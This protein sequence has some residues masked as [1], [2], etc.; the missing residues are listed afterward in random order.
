VGSA[1][2]VSTE[3]TEEL[4]ALVREI[5]D[6]VR[7]RYPSADAA[8]ASFP[9]ADLTALV[10][11]RDVAESKVASIGT[12]NPRPPGLLNNLIQSAKRLVTRALDWHVR[13]QVEF[14]RAAV[15]GLNSA[16]EALN[17]TNRAL[18]HLAR[19]ESDIREVQQIRTDWDLWRQAWER[20]LTESEIRLLRDVT[21][22]QGAFQQRVH[23]IENNFREL[24]R[25]QHGEFR[26]ALDASALEIQQRLWDSLAQLRA[27]QEQLIHSELRL[28]RQRAATLPATPPAVTSAPIPVAVPSQGAFD[29]L[30][31]A[32]RFRGTE[33]RVRGC[34]QTFAER[35]Q[36][37]RNVIDLGCGRGEFLGLMK[38]AGI[39]CRG[40]DSSG[41][42][43]AICR[44][45]Q[46]AA[47]RADIFEY[48]AAEPDASLD[49]IFCAQVIEHLPPNRLP[50]LVR[51]AAAKL[52][53]GG[54]LVVETP[55]PE[56]L[57]IFCTYFYV[58]P[59]HTRPVPAQLLAFYLEEAGFGGIEIERLSPAEE[60]LPALAELPASVREALFGG[61]DYAAIARR[62]P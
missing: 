2:E 27:D 22:L 26:S 52:Q 32:E 6:R 46:L 17:E 3:K 5:R 4:A 29:Y 10:H 58:D 61:L 48:L 49:G 24:V 8:P 45:R 11:A 33:E 60:I 21:E 15:T 25:S 12:V 50:V 43:V 23:Q 31:F 1:D 41:E 39:P 19:M 53:A 7:A 57:A 59:T 54:L 37:C 20:K 34:Q 9:L 47:E 55:N 14:N 36:G 40:I 30:G 38:E 44:S 16:I 35:F 56:C 42:F 18:V 51:L 28:I 62:L 13:E